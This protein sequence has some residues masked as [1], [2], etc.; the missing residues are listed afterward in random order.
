MLAKKG[1][2]IGQ[3]RVVEIFPRG[4]QAAARYSSLI[5]YKNAGNIVE[6]DK[7]KY[8][9]KDIINAAGWIYHGGL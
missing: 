7:K 6:L 1:R 4:S 9:E 2:T 5:T 3:H 8:Y